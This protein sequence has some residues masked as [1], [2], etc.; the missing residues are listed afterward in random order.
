MPREGRRSQVLRIIR[1]SHA[2]LDD[3]EI[4]QV[5]TMNRVYVNVICRQLASD[6]LIVRTPGPDGKLVNRPAGGGQ[7][8]AVLMPNGGQRRMRQPRGVAGRLAERIED[9]IGG[10]AEYVTMFEANEAFPGPS[11]YFHLRAIDRRR[12]HQTVRSL[13]NDTQFLEYAYAVLPAWGMHRM[14]AQ[15]A[16]V[17]DFSQITA[18]LRETAP[19]LEQ[20]WPLRI[21]SLSQLEADKAAATAW[22]VIAHIKVST[23]K[24]QIVA[25]SKMLHHVLPDLIPPI[26]RQYTFRFFTGQMVVT[27]D[28]TAFLSWM[29]QTREHRGTMST[30]DPGR[31]PTQRLHGHRGGEDHRQ[32]HHR[33]H[34]ASTPRRRS[35]QSN[36][37]AIAPYLW[38]TPLTP[39][40][41]G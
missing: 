34:A 27:S 9:L 21:T 32:R 19:A 41:R 36:P 29:P 40:L 15:A 16:K 4:A 12:Q 13:L 22:E 7:A 25:G 26:D 23:S 28:R 35:A 6:R 5:A 1:Q 31:Y 2:A 11:L 39:S 18:A 33:L 10:F 14:G 8:S 24:T 3:D 37:V 38:T 17:G 20:L 30:T